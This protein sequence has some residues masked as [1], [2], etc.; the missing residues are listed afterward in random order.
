METTKMTSLERAV[1]GTNLINRL[2]IEN[3][4]KVLPQL[5]A[6]KNKKVCLVNGTKAKSFNVELLSYTDNNGQELRTYIHFAS[7]GNAENVLVYIKQDVTI[8]DRNYEGGGYG[9]TYFKNDIHI[10][11][12][13]NG[14]L[15]EVY[16]L[17]QIVKSYSLNTVFCAKEVKQT[18]DRIE[19]LK[20][21]VA[22]LESLI[23]PFK[24][25]Y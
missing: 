8:K 7:Y 10:G 21:E 20:N 6:Y 16:S 13:D 18:K 19:Q 25:N 12:A 23:Y 5:A 14:I 9:V 22:G 15:K 24:N 2:T 17:E 3:L 1:Y 11:L 4:T